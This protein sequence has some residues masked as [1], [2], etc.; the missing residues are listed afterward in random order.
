MKIRWAI[1]GAL[2]G[3]CNCDW[4][5]PCSFDAR[6]T[7]GFCEGGYVWHIREGHIGEISIAGMALAIFGHSPGPIHEGNLTTQ[8]LVEERANPAQR[9][10]LLKLAHGG[11]GG[12]WAIFAAVTAKWLE[13][14]FAPFNVHLDGLNSQ[15]QAGKALEI[16]LGPILNPVTKEP[17]EIYLDKPTGFTAKRTALGRSLSFRVASGL[18]YDHSGKYGEF[19]QFE[20]SGEGET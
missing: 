8:I 12:P 7:Q 14:E 17:E 2:L 13:P 15:A 9:D 19:S 5:C 20:Y 16:K 4:G 3:A 6:P 10:V 18:Q 1:K 11:M